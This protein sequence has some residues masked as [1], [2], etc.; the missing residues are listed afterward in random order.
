[1]KI[2]IC[3]NK[4]Q[5]LAA[6]VSAYSFKRFG[7]DDIE[8]L[9]IEKNEILN[10]K[11]NSTY[12]RKG[13]ITKF[14]DDL[15]SFTLLRFFPFSQKKSKNCLI[16]DPDIFAINNPKKELEEFCLKN[17]F[18]IGCTKINGTFRSEVMLLKDIN[19]HWN[20]EEII[21]DIFNHNLDYKDLINL[22][23]KKYFTDIVTLPIIFNHHDKIEYDTILLHTTKRITQP[24]KLGL[25]INFHDEKINTIHKIKQYLKKLLK[26][27]YDPNVFSKN[28]VMHSDEK[29]YQTVLDL[30]KS[31]INSNAIDKNELNKAI[32]N[33]YISSEFARN[34]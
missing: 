20:Y 27:K 25:E 32:K 3:A 21:E 10:K 22:T 4:Y 14:I 31:A 6:K 17:D 2:F 7:F 9:E 34:L 8:I 1:M 15:Q 16:I 11:F 30:F 24:W 33:K 26:L 5:K 12:L 23:S 19:N 29:V 28:Y 18:K 13:K